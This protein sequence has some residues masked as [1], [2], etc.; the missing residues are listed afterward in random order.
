MPR[1]TACRLQINDRMN[2]V[3]LPCFSQT[4]SNYYYTV[5]NEKQPVRMRGIKNKIA[6][7]YI[8][9]PVYLCV[10]MV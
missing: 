1:T 6:T 7:I 5:K 2:F 10:F 3:K 8:S 9:H 4:V